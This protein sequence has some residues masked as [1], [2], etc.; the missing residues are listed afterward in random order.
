MNNYL[1]S[2]DYFIDDLLI[3]N[4][5]LLTQ[6]LDFLLMQHLFESIDLEVM[7]KLE[8]QDLYPFAAWYS[9]KFFYDKF[10]APFFGKIL[11]K[12]VFLIEGSSTDKTNK[13]KNK[14]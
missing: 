3:S 4:T 1:E 8:R 11:S 2:F 14:K 13:E 9:M 7:N 12:F 10:W 6:E 5:N